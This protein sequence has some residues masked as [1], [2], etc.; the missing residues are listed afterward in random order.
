MPFH[1]LRIAIRHLLRSPGFTTTAVLMLALGIGATTAIFS[2]VEGVLLRPLPFPHSERLVALS[3]ILQGAEL[4]GN[5]EAGVTAPDIRAYTRDTHSFEDLGGYLQLSYELSGI[6]EPAQV[7]A[8]R[9]SGG[10]LPALGVAP[11]MGR[12][13]TQQ[14]DDR[15]EQVTVVSY[16]LWQ[17]RLHGDPHVLGSKILLDRKPY[18]VIGVM[19]RDFEFPLVP[20][21]LNNSELWVP[22]SFTQQE[23]TTGAASW[24]FNMVG[25]LKAGITPAQAESDAER[26]AQATMRSYPPFM[27]SLHIRAVVHSLHEETVEQARQLVRTLFLATMVVLLIACA[28]LAGLLLVR[29][30]RRRRQIAVQMALGAPAG[31]LL[32]EALLESL[33]LS[34]TGGVL[35]LGLAAIALRVG[36]RLLPETL[37]RI[38][39]VGLDGKVV[40]FAIVLSVLT[41]VVCGLA[42]TFAAL[43]TNIS[44]TLK[45]GGRA[46]AAGGG[47]A[48]L[49]SALVVGEIAIAL[50]LLAA[51]GL[52]LRSF[53]KMRAVDLGFRPDHVLTA[54]YSLP[55]K[56]YT[57]QAAVDEFNHELI[58]RL[59]QL[60]GVKFAGLTSFLPASGGN[61][62]STFVAEGYVA[63]I[64][65]GMNLATIVTVE[66]DYMQA[67][68]VPL[69]SGRFFTAAD[70]ADTPLVAIV[71][72]KLAEHYWPGS[73]PLG[74][75]LRMGMQETKTPWITIVGEVADVKESSP[76][77]PNKEQYYEP[78]EQ[79][80][81]SIGDFASPTDLNGNGGSIVVRTAV[82]PEQMANVLRATVRSIDAQLPL[83]QVQTMERTVSD[84]EAPRRFNTTVISA[85]ATAAVLLAALGMYSVIAFSTALRVQEMA[86]RIALGSQRA[87]ILGLVFVSAAKL[88]IA[89]CVIGLLGAAAASRLLGSFL[90]G[91]S[92]FDPLVL[93]LAAVFVLLLAGLASLLPAR[94]AA[95]VDLMSV[96][97]A[98]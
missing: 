7:N 29:A 17:N 6:G 27:S 12:F 54:S 96:L 58:R 70:T 79:A 40:L 14:E 49:R 71:N 50:V 52:L 51:S 90:F 69:L 3:D 26:V 73:N 44:E 22:M 35:G 38:Q 28:N 15:N 91:V 59:Q 62:N 45:E 47:H 41:G 81:K 25:R 98:D 85:F 89:G 11:L 77:V 53:E 37:P 82:E 97:R 43:R 63:P 21:H 13:F 94:R 68:G 65:A 74:K 8:A 78:V 31:A 56:Q 75:R 16:G 86:I 20:G 39:E 24:N 5:G 23:L 2:L 9:L 66:G 83:A 60:P 34:V 88:A 92:P 84:S 57:T 42:P 33:V 80:E 19:P 30:V 4:G 32:G 64:G 48:W 55:Q 67:I 76:D 18:I 10:V 87:G 1:D 72:H 95:S 36:V 93:T 61:S 46:G